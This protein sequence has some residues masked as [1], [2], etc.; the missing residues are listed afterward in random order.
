MLSR[1]IFDKA[2]IEI[3]AEILEHASDVF[4]PDGPRRIEMPREVDQQTYQIRLQPR[5]QEQPAFK[6]DLLWYVPYIKIEASK[7][8]GRSYAEMTFERRSTPHAWKNLT[9]FDAILPGP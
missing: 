6:L 9:R 8:I 7:A 5:D 3:R 4:D 1:R 2:P